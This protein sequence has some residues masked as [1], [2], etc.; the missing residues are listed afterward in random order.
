MTTMDKPL[1]ITIR[2]L[3]L[4][5]KYQHEFVRLLKEDDYP[6]LREVGVVTE[7]WLNSLS[8]TKTEG[9]AA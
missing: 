5:P 4:S 2:L 7:N 8:I 6:E 1:D 3:N 9:D